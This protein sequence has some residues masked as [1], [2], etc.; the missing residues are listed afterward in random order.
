[1]AIKKIDLILRC[2]ELKSLEGITLVS[3][4]IKKYSAH[5]RS[6]QCPKR[7]MFA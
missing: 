7:Q 4:V 5:V 6:G 2:H 3:I 1:M